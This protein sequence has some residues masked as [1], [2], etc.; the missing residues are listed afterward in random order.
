MNFNPLLI[1][2]V[3]LIFS[4][5]LAA[6]EK[7]FEGLRI[8]TNGEFLLKE[9]A[10]GP[11]DPAGTKVFSNDREILKIRINK[12]FAPGTANKIINQKATQLRSIYSPVDVP[13]AGAITN[14]ANCSTR[15]SLAAHPV[16]T[17]DSLVVSFDLEAN[18][19]LAYGECEATKLI[20]KSRYELLY[21]KHSKIYFEIKYFF[22]KD[23]KKPSITDFYCVI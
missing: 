14:S 8:Q 21:C 1:F 7:A 12:D 19:Q 22:I 2:L 10:E 11:R 18:A 3:S 15:Y 17:V 9:Q 6:N 5:N 23:L 13:Y 4:L 16:E 20:Y